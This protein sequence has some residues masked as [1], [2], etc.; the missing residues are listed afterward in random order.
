MNSRISLYLFG[1]LM[2]AHEAHF[3]CYVIYS[4][5]LELADFNIII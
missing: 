3:F 1:A 2:L 4:Y 5:F